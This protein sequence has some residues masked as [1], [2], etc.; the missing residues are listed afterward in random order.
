ML[1]QFSVANCLSFNEKTTLEFFASKD[2]NLKEQ[3]W[4]SESSFIPNILKRALFGLM[5][6]GKSNLIKAFY[7]AKSIVLGTKSKKP[8]NIL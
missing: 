2:R 1:I 5:L 3:L 4:I 8:N 7:Y 6:G